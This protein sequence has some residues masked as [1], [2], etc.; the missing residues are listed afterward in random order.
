M[1]QD[2]QDVQPVIHGQFVLETTDLEVT[3]SL[4]DPPTNI[5]SSAT[6]FTVALSFQAQPGLPTWI[7]IRNSSLPYRVV[8]L[9]ESVG[10]HAD[11]NL[12]TRAL[13]F[14][15]GLDLY[16]AAQTA[17]VV[18]ANFLQP[19]IYRLAAQISVNNFPGFAGFFE[20]EL[21]EII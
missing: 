2:S 11:A 20:G 1:S 6:P 21:F 18:P 12:G 4:G 19:G 10:P 9:A 14:I 8:Y 16:T 17:L 13:N 3:T 15:P 7:G 5:I